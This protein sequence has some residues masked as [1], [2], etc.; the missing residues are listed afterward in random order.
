[1]ANE[2]QISLGK[3]AE[4]ERNMQESVKLCREIEIEWREADAHGELGELFTYMGQFD[5]AEKEFAI[6][7][8]LGHNEPVRLVPLL[9]HRS[10]Y[11]RLMRDK[12]TMLNTSQKMRLL[13]DEVAKSQYPVAS[14][15]ICAE[16][17]LG[18]AL[19]MD[20]KDLTAATTHLTEAL[21]CCRAIN[22]IEYEANILLDLA[23]LRYDQESYEEAKSLAEEALLITERCGYVLQGADVNLFLAQYALDQEKD[24]ARAKEYAETALKLAYCDGPPYYYK[25]A[26]EEAK[27][28][29][30]RLKA[31]G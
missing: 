11:A 15:N 28:M 1:M 4:A 31:E 6:S 18:A 26:Y 2:A 12:D 29:L 24:K 27:R 14:D 23:R 20:G 7:L 10:I 13:V 22:Y 8:E 3:L 21:T 30:E 25:V 17:L 19:V 5:E 9:F 16:W